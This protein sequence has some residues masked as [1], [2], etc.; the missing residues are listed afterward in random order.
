LHE[1]IEETRL[2]DSDLHSQDF[3]VKFRFPWP[4]GH[5]WS[6]V[7]VWHQGKEGIRWRQI[8]GSLHANRGEIS[9]GTRDGQAHVDYRAAIDVGLPDLFTQPYK[10]R[11]VAEFLG[12]VYDRAMKPGL[13]L[14]TSTQP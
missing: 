13:R 1:W 11:F 10:K 4:V 3:L 6:R 14:A 12:A 8:E 2:V 9:F 7:R 5:Q